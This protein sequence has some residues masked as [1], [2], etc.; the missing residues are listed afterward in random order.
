MTVDTGKKETSNCHSYESDVSLNCRHNSQQL[1]AEM[2]ILT[3]MQ[4]PFHKTDKFH[5]MPEP[6]FR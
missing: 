1:G 4:S 3:I 6:Y 5:V 2:P